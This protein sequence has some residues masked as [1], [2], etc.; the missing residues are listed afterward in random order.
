MHTQGVSIQLFPVPPSLVAEASTHSSWIYSSIINAV[1]L[2]QV[3]KDAEECHQCPRPEVQL[4]VVQLAA[5]SF[6]AEAATQ[7]LPTAQRQVLAFCER[8]AAPVQLLCQPYLSAGLEQHVASPTGSALLAALLQQFVAAPAT[9]Q[10]PPEQ[11]PATAP[12][13]AEQQPEEPFVPADH[14]A[15]L[16]VGCSSVAACFCKMHLDRAAKQLSELAAAQPTAPAAAHLQQLPRPEREL[17]EQPVQLLCFSTPALQ[18]FAAAAVRQHRLL[19]DISS[20]ASA[21][22]AAT[23]AVDAGR[24]LLGRRCLL[25][26]LASKLRPCIQQ[27]TAC[28]A[29]LEDVWLE[30]GGPAAVPDVEAFCTVVATAEALARMQ[31]PRLEA[32][33]MLT[34][35][36]EHSL[37]RGPANPEV[38][39]GVALEFALLAS[40]SQRL[41]AGLAAHTAGV[42][43]P[44]LI[45]QAGPAAFQLAVTAGKFMWHHRSFECAPGTTRSSAAAA[46]AAGEALYHLR[47]PASFFCSATILAVR[48]AVLALPSASEPTERER[49]GRRLD[50]IAL[51]ALDALPHS[52]TALPC[53][54]G[55]TYWPVGHPNQLPTVLE[56]LRML[57]AARHLHPLL[58]EGGWGGA[59]RRLAL[60]LLVVSRAAA[61]RWYFMAALQVSKLP[62]PAQ[63]P[64]TPGPSKGSLCL[65]P[66]TAGTPEPCR[67]RSRRP[68]P[69]AQPHGGR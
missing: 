26:P 60:R 65:N 69:L 14:L 34:G 15:Y 10:L 27:W 49:L 64:V 54:T 23:A 68:P 59:L 33:K 66:H 9:D 53:H 63:R 20:V 52:E 45:L 67:I 44:G 39:L 13:A 6:Q 5:C 43:E 47:S 4:A 55:Q 3:D 41:L 58:L 16:L 22:A 11:L 56:L 18:L 1:G 24:P 17:L 46:A 62:V 2:I 7:H 30:G 8:Q 35:A 21:A 50:A 19:S 38:H 32:A 48:A 42:A 57:F 28:C 36:V 40:G 25:P 31:V 12:A 37:F 29:L 61:G 51:A